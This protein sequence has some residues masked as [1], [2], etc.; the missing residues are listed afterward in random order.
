MTAAYTIFCLIIS[1]LN[2]EREKYKV[3]VINIHTRNP[4]YLHNFDFPKPPPS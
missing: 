1:S 2:C 4:R 3:K